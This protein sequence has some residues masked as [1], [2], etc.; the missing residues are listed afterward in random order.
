ME[1]SYKN[2]GY[3]FITLWIIVLIGFHQTYTV[4]F[5]TF[6]GFRWEQHFHGAMLMAWLSML[7]VQPFLIKF[8]K[9]EWHR[10]L[11]KVGYVYSTLLK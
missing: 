7:M 9:Y 1:K 10:T 8:G 3:F 2:I 4:F 11:G 6:K 5:P